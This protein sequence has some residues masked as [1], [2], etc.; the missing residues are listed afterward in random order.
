MS[1]LP[2]APK[3]GNGEIE[4]GTPVGEVIIEDAEEP[5]FGQKFGLVGDDGVEIELGDSDS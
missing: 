2:G 3:G 4:R 5:Q 1:D